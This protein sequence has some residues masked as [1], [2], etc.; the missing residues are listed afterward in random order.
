[1][2]N[3][4]ADLHFHPVLTV[5]FLDD[6]IDDALD[7]KRKISIDAMDVANELYMDFLTS[8][9]LDVQIRFAMLV[10]KYDPLF[11]DCYLRLID[12]TPATHN[13]RLELLLRLQK[14]AEIRLGKDAVKKYKPHFYGFLETRPYMRIRYDIAT[15]YMEME[16]FGDAITVFQAMLTL[17]ENDN[18]GVRYPL[19]CLHLA[20]SD[21][22][23]ANQ[24]FDAIR[25][26]IGSSEKNSVFLKTSVKKN[27]G[28]SEFAKILKEMMGI[29]NKNKQQND[30]RKLETE[31]KDIIL[32]NM[33]KKMEA[34][35]SVDKTFFKY[36]KKIQLK[37]M[38]PFEAADKITKSM[39][40]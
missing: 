25:E 22:D 21:L 31:L 40:K 13:E 29:K 1:M 3:K 23:G 27:S 8:D 28:I 14:L 11:T 17:S 19:L 18:L 36:L 30:M 24:L 15:T 4:P 33:N 37:E 39:I 9:T 34:M 32:N 7:Q 26:Y 5:E 2:R 38:D 35:L 12:M 10:L 6:A 16:Q 20:Q